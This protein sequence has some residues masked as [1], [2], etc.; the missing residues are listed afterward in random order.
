[1]SAPNIREILKYEAAVQNAWRA[2]LQ[3]AG[4]PASQ[5]FIEFLNQSSVTPR[6]E[7]NLTNIV[8]TLHRGQFLPGQFT[9]DA[10]HGQL[11]TRVITRRNMNGAQHDEL[12]GIAR[13][14]ALYFKNRFTTTLLPWH[15]MTQIEE[16]ST[17]RMI[18]P[19]RDED[20]TE[21]THKIIISVRAGAWPAGEP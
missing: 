16:E 18:D 17:H 9:F 4:V 1:V 10:W 15:T 6:M 20:I 12:L 11:I 7:I 21:L 19:E 14:E 5:L 13:S 3:N 8:P 2:I